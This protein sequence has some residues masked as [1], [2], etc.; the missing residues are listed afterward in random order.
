MSKPASLPPHCMYW[1]LRQTSVVIIGGWNQAIFTPQWVYHH[2]FA[3][4][5]DPDTGDLLLSMGLLNTGGYLADYR[6]HGVV[7]V[8]QPAKLELRPL[9]LDDAVFDEVEAT[10]IRI[11]KALPETP[12]EAVGV[13]VGKEV[14][15]ELIDRYYGCA[16]SDRFAAMGFT[17]RDLQVW[18]LFERNE[19]LMRVM[20]RQDD[21]RVALDFNR[22]IDARNLTA[23]AVVPKLRGAFLETREV[24]TEILE[25]L[26][27]T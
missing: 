1:D 20:A 18:R 27:A 22:H 11:L 9:T 7:L 25:A 16:D 5:G 17:R 13:N 6:C 24:A 23:G 15:P 4:E 21:Q 10:A 14:A 26:E 8:V 12:V 3:C 19:K 2:A